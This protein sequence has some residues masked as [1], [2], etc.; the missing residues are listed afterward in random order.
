MSTPPALA[1]QPFSVEAQQRGRRGVPAIPRWAIALAGLGLAAVAA[2]LFATERMSMAAALVAA[3]CVGPIAFLDLPLAL[4]LY[5]VVLYVQDIPALSVGPNSMGVLVAAG[6]AG[7]I[8]VRRPRPP[9][10]RNQETLLASLLL[11]SLW[12]TFTITWSSESGAT[13]EAIKSWLIAA[14]GFLVSATALRKGRDVRIVAIAFVLGS[15]ASVVYGIFSG[16]LT[17]AASTANEAARFTGGGGDP[18]VQAAGFVAGMFLAAGLWGLARD[19]LQRA[20]LIS[21]FVA[22]T[23]GFF[24]TQSRGGLIGL[25]AAAIAGIVMLPRQRRRLLGLAGAAAIGLAVVAITNASAV[26][27]MTDLGGGTSGRT[28]LWTVAAR[29]FEDHRWIG[30][31]LGA[32]QS[33]EPSYSL[34]S[35]PLTRV[36]LVV[37]EPHLVHNVYLQLA[38]ETGV[39]GLLLFLFFLFMCLRAAWLAGKTFA[40]SGQTAASDLAGAVLMGAV[41][42]LTAEFFISDGDD[43]RLWI[44]LGMGPALL[45]IARQAQSQPRPPDVRARDLRRPRRQRRAAISSS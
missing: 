25:A 43:W 37:Q 30:I 13:G 6:W 28:D 3:V 16:D 11:F 2:H 19:G 34:R 26:Q 31:G 42:M 36:D 35:G 4:A 21:C 17:A 8:A 40:A 27:R 10:L 5:V 12:I 1:A 32:F 38:T 7:A 20:A 33:V 24:L 22:I 44:L 29:I 39:V 18:N 41:G 9:F 15:A 23:I 45:A 14:L